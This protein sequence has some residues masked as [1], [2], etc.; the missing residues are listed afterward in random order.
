MPNRTVTLPTEAI[1][2]LFKGSLEEVIEMNLETDNRLLIGSDKN[3]S[4]RFAHAAR[5][6]M[7]HMLAPSEFD[8]W[9][10]DV[11]FPQ[12]DAFVEYSNK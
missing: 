4:L 3:E 8:T 1:D 11:Y 6:L 7:E 12:L 9:M 2:K 10:D 5:V